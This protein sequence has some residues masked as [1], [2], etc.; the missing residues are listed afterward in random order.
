MASLVTRGGRVDF[1]MRAQMSGA[2]DQD[3]F[4]KALLDYEA[5]Y[6][7]PFGWI[8]NSFNTESGD[9][10]I[11]LNV[12]VGDDNEDEVQAVE[13]PM[14]MDKA[15]GLKKKGA[16]VS[17][18]SSSTNEEALARLMVSELA[19]HNERSMAMKKEELLAFL[20]IRRWKVEIHERELAMQ[21]YKQCQKDIGSAG[22]RINLNVDV[23]DNNE[24]EDAN[25]VETA[26]GLW[27]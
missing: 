17:G 5:E 21:E 13:R 25:A 27:K 4:E 2:G 9:A 16:R 24:D 10:R 18:S 1:G 19:M 14:G 3:Y 12:D 20:E 8:L 22:A 7:V 6:G 15:K 23:G 26:N 11:N